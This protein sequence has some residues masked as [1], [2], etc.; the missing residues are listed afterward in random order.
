MRSGNTKK[1]K[2]IID[3]LRKYFQQIC[4]FVW[5]IWLNMMVIIFD[6]LKTWNLVIYPGLRLILWSSNFVWIN[7]ISKWKTI[8]E[9][10]QREVENRR[11]D[12]VVINFSPHF[13]SEIGKEEIKESKRIRCDKRYNLIFFSVCFKQG[14]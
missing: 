14:R 9:I 4:P 2:D 13:N 3:F 11:D 6:K 1:V 5:F 7:I 12:E 10:K 8:T